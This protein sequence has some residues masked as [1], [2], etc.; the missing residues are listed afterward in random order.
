MHQAAETATVSAP[1]EI[2]CGIDR[3]F[4]GLLKERADAKS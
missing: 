2:G 4:A 3:P 1:A